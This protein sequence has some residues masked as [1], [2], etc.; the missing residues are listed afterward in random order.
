MIDTGCLGETE[1]YGQNSSILQHRRRPMLRIS[2]ITANLS[3]GV[4]ELRQIP[5]FRLDPQREAGAKT[6]PARSFAD[7]RSG[8]YVV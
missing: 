6:V 4:A 7:S 2:E 8:A 3:P 1:N 5:R